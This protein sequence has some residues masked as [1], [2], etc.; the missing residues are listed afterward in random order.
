MAKH[1]GRRKK[2]TRFAVLP[3]ETE[4]ALGTL[5]ENTVLSGS[6]S[7]VLLEDFYATSVDIT[8]V[9]KGATADEGPVTVGVSH[10]D[11]AVAEIK[12]YLDVNYLGPGTKIEQEQARRLIR[13]IGTFHQVA[14]Q[15]VL[16]H[17]SPIRTKLKFVLDDGKGLN[18]WAMNRGSGATTGRIIQISGN[19]YGRWM[20]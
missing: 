18:F 12:E 7:G 15:E 16:N 14:T 10:S 1:K 2:D 4:L 5:A 13:R 19:I 20:Y 9:M 3:F 17:G 11:Y 6:V 8:W